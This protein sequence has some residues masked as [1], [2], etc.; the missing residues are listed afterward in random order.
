M[1]SLDLRVGNPEV[2]AAT[3]SPEEDVTITQL[4][5]QHS[6]KNSGPDFLVVPFILY[7]LPGERRD[8][9]AAQFPPVVT[10]QLL[11]GPRK[12]ES[13]PTGPFLLL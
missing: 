1:D 12:E 11:P 7:N 3:V 4:A 8:A 5:A 10:Q 6:Q 13:A 9:L 2:L